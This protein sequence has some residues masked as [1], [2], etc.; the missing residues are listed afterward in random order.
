MPKEFDDDDLQDAIASGIDAYT[1]VQK[2]SEDA[3][4]CYRAADKINDLNQ[5]VDAVAACDAIL[6]KAN[7]ILKHADEINGPLGLPTSD[8]GAQNA[9]D[10]AYRDTYNHFRNKS[11]EEIQAAFDQVAGQDNTPSKR[12]ALKALKDLLQ[13][14]GFDPPK[15]RRPT[16]APPAR[17]RRPEPDEQPDLGDGGGTESMKPSASSMRARPGDLGAR[18][19]RHLVE[20]LM[21]LASYWLVE[22]RAG[23]TLHFSDDCP[24]CAKA[25]VEA[26]EL[27]A[28]EHPLALAEQ[29]QARPCGTCL[30]MAEASIREGF[31]FGRV[32]LTKTLAIW[33]DRIEY[34][35]PAWHHLSR[36]QITIA[37][38]DISGIEFTTATKLKISTAEGELDI[39]CGRPADAEVAREALR[40][41]GWTFGD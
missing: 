37:L 24:A 21:P 29:L 5:K 1:Q 12:P 20:N 22:T 10:K 8:S 28:P 30:R 7:F 15:V 6:R 17:H 3:D 9:S 23:A 11:P 4:A 36:R 13:K 16:T 19:P 27:E 38:K 35:G 2:L 32:T 40:R 39:S 25:G 18:Y 14:R 31:L 34:E 33:R 26:E 41:L